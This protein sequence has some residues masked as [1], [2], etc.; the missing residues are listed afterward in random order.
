MQVRNSSD[1]FGA[2]AM[3]LHWLTVLLIAGAWLLGEFIDVFAK[4]APRDAALSVHMMFGLA[5]LLTLVARFLWREFDGVPR[6]EANP[7]DPWLHR[8][9]TLVHWLLYLLL[10]VT[11]IVG[12]T[13]ASARGNTVPVFGLFDITPWLTPDRQLA[14]TILGIHTL[15]ANALVILALAHA[16]AALI[17]HWFFKDRTLTR[18]LPGR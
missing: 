18:M 13:L 17:H 12:I 3:S 15:L 16:G 1:R 10:A 5:V 8:L 2:V 6:P 11:P 14:R 4:G 7:L 9:A